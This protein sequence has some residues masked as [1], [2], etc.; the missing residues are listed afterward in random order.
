MAR[1]LIVGGSLGGLFAGNMLLRD[2]HDVRIMER[3]ATLLDGRGAGIVTHLALNDALLKAGL[4]NLD[5]L[6]VEVTRRIVLAPDGAVDQALATQQVLTSWSRLYSFLK[7][8]FPQERYIHDA[9]FVELRQSTGEVHVTLRRSGTEVIEA[10]DLLI[11]CD[12]I[13]SSVRGQL[14]PGVRSQYAGYIAWRGICE[15]RDLSAA[16][17]ETLFDAFAFGLGDDEQILGYPV[18]GRGDTTE[19]GGRRYNTVWYRNAP[20]GA[21]LADLMTDENGLHFPNG[22]PPASVARRHIAAMR[23]DACKLLAP[24]FREVLEKTEQPFLQP[25]YDLTCDEIALGRVALAGDA[26]FVARPHVGMGVTKA[27]Q[28]ASV[29]T[30]CI[31]KHGATPQALNAYQ[32]CRLPAGQAV[33]QRGREL[34]QYMNTQAHRAEHHHSASS[35]ALWVLRNVAVDSSPNAAPS[36]R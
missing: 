29:L 1:I 23:E 25:I 18:A 7:G 33:V 12:G 27:A 36:P 28:D 34:G 14:W 6:G 22:I 24:Q 13:R 9:S 11:G 2:G 3:S 30:D 16:A 4:T 15:E 10:A 8:L 26:A 35:Q 5:G 21:G 32:S 17:R 19:R 31:R 20:P